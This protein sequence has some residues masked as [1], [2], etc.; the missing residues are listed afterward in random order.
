MNS[1][2]SESDILGYI[3]KWIAADNV[4]HLYFAVLVITG[5]LLFLVSYL[6]S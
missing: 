4:I 2:I 3:P 1:T 6:S 5:L